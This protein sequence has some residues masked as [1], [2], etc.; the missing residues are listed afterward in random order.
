MNWKDGYSTVLLFG[1]IRMGFCDKRMCSILLVRR[2]RVAGRLNRKTS[3]TSIGWRFSI[4]IS[5]VRFLLLEGRLGDGTILNYLTSGR[6][7]LNRRFYEGTG[8]YCSR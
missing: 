4:F 1:E 7:C 8:L 5:A 2:F 3:S 6:V